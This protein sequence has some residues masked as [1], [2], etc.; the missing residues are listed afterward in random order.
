MME[1]WRILDSNSAYIKGFEDG[2]F[3][4][5]AFDAEEEGHAG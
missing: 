3:V 4:W 1:I 2:I 5:W